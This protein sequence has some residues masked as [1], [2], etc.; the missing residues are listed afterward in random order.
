MRKMPDPLHL[1][2]LTEIDATALTRDRTR[3]APEPQAEL[4]ATNAPSGLRQPTA[5]VPLLA[6]RGSHRHGLHT[7]FLRLHAFRTLHETTGQDS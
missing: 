3:L 2:P 7:G 5:H 6:P 4:E 1:V